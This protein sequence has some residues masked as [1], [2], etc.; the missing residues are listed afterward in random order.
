MSQVASETLKKMSHL[1]VIFTTHDLI[2][3]YITTQVDSFRVPRTPRSGYES[4]GG[5]AHDQ[6]TTLAAL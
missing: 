4:R 2:A 5:R 3:M 6:A 1:A